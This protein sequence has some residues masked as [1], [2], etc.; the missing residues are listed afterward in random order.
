VIRDARRIGFVH[1]LARHFV[2][3][4]PGADGQFDARRARRRTAA[5]G[6]RDDVAQLFTRV[7]VAVSRRRVS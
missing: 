2:T 7:V 1:R 3:P 4:R 5:K 6:Q